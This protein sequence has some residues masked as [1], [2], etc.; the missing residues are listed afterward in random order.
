MRYVSYGAILVTSS[1]R[2]RSAWWHA[3]LIPRPKVPRVT[4]LTAGTKHFGKLSLPIASNAESVLNFVGFVPGGRGLSVGSLAQVVAN[5]SGPLQSSRRRKRPGFGDSLTKDG[6]V[7]RLT[8]CAVSDI[9]AILH[10]ER[11]TIRLSLPDRTGRL[12][13]AAG[14]G[15]GVDLG[16]KRSHIRRAVFETK[17]P[18]RS[19]LGT[20]PNTLAFL[21]LVYRDR[22]V[23]VVE[24]LASERVIAERWDDLGRAV[25]RA[26]RMI[27]RA[28]QT[29]PGDVGFEDFRAVLL[30]RE[31]IRANSART[32]LGAALD[33]SHE[34]FDG[35]LAGWLVGPG[36][37]QL[38]LVGVRGLG[39]RKGRELRRGMLSLPRWESLTADERQ[40]KARQFGD[41]ID[42][43]EVAVLLAG[44]A[45]I[46][47]RNSLSSASRTFE[48]LGPLLEDVF[49][50]LA[51]VTWAERRNTYLDLGIALTAHEIKG[52]ISGARAAID[53]LLSTTNGP[54]A[55]R[56]LLSRSSH[57]LDQL[58]RLVHPLLRWAVGVGLMRRRRM[59]VVKIVREAEQSCRLEMGQDRI[60][61]MAPGPA[62]VSADPK[63]L[64]GAI[65]NVLRNALA[66][67]P[68]DSKVTIVVEVAEEVVTI[69][70]KDRGP[71]LPANEREVIFD[72]FVRGA[73]SGRSRSG[74]GLGLFIA[75]RVVEAHE[76][77][78]WVDSNR[79]GTTFRIQLPRRKVAWRSK[80][81]ASSSSKTTSYSPM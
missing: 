65:A 60:S 49:D 7:A 48:V 27:H 59:D 78:I 32:A 17:R 81:S 21:P 40:G 54:V 63:H 41:I 3:V 36:Q 29:P 14:L 35:P 13:R 61:I 8:T 52:P 37:Q 15:E 25:G 34:R 62:I 33:Y 45:L 42:A 2:N 53:H 11:A 43:D 79:A 18:I 69:S 9:Q 30:V 22:A 1:R 66:Y 31:M 50:H 74:S 64:R 24:V 51:V 72:P 38:G 77:R 58:L 4:K 5:E 68:Q 19:A 67:A 46:F 76:G 20:G 80:G 70:V 12:R 55:Q 26:A 57:E 23:G 6:E 73:A 28:G 56:E 71:G 10:P 39:S 75:R 44:D 16:R 47:A